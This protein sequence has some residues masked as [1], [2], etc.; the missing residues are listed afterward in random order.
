MDQEFESRDFSLT[1]LLAASGRGELEGFLKA[2]RRGLD[3]QGWD[4]LVAEAIATIETGDLD[5]I[6]AM[7]C[8]NE[9]RIPFAVLQFL[10]LA[11]PAFPCDLSTISSFIGTLAARMP[12]EGIPHYLVNGYVG[13]CEKD[14]GRPPAALEAIRDGIVPSALLWSTLVVGLKSDR[15]TFLAVALRMLAEGTAEERRTAAGVLG[16]F[17]PFSPDERERVVAGLSG[18]IVDA[19]DYEKVAPLRAMLAIGLRAP[20]NEQIGLSALALVADCPGP[21][22]REA[23]AMELMFSRGKA[24]EELISRAIEP[25]RETQASELAALDGIDH[26][27]SEAL[28]KP[29]WKDASR[30]LD[31]LLATGAATMGRLD[32]T[33]NRLLTGEAD[34]LSATVA[35]W[36]A[37]DDIHHI[38]AVRDLCRGAGEEAPIFELDFGPESLSPARATR[39]ARRCCALLILFSAT[40]ASVLV[41]LMRTG[42]AQAVPAIAQLL[43]DPLLVNY[44]SGP[45]TYL[46]SVGA[47][48]PPAVAAAIRSVLEAHDR[49]KRGI[50]AA[51]YIAEIQ[52]SQHHRFLSG[53]KRHDEQREINKAAQKASVFASIFPTSLLLYGDAVIFDVHVEPGK[54]VR[55]E[56]RMQTHEFSQELPRLEII[57]PFAAWYQRERLLVDEDNE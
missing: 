52:P 16:Q 44:W 35:G 33:Q 23:I 2:A 14:T 50:E 5:L 41:S 18:A 40:I 43:F 1:E 26:I 37:S 17:E 21:A 3:E 22:I 46:E 54:T 39:L 29:G 48:A 47:G 28:G 19:G 31:H 30:L 6:A 10:E 27:L 11:I 57:A 32:S 49:Y 13:W 34:L 53:M 36:L 12:G 15:P 38:V 7:T 8:G 25:L 9:G 56:T 24:S 42:P 20:A 51:G 4:T 55:E 45:R